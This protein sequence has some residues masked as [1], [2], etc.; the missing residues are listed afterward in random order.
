[1][2][3]KGVID[4]LED[5]KLAVILVESEGLEYVV[6]KEKLPKEAGAGTWLTFVVE[7]NNMTDI[8][9]DYAKTDQSLVNANAKLNR[10]RKKSAGSKFKKK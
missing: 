2:N 8:S 7:N 4:R 1:M 10:I 6:P 9:I 5:N 3:K